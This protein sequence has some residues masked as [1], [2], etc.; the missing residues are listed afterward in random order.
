ML[1]E[2]GNA[3]TILADE[4]GQRTTSAAAAA[5][6]LPYD[7]GAGDKVMEWS[8]ATYKRLRKLAA[9]PQTGVS[10]L[11][12][13][14][15]SRRHPLAVPPWATAL[16]A[17]SLPNEARRGSGPLLFADGY[18]L[19]VPLMDT[20]RYLSYLADRLA[21]LGGT[22][23]KGVHLESFQDVS[24]GSGLDLI[25]NCA[26]IGARELAPD[27]EL[28][29]HRG[30]VAIVP[31]LDLPFAVACDDPPLM[32]AIPRERDCVFGGT[33]C[34]SGN[35]RPSAGETEAIVN[36][37]SRMLNIPPPCVLDSRVGLRPYRRPGVRLESGKL[38]D[39]TNIIHNYGHG[40]SGFTLSWGCAEEVVRLAQSLTSTQAAGPK[41]KQS[42]ERN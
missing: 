40:G 34:V 27:S 7:V 1:A 28:E 39:G 3:V 14:Q 10:M 13:R 29:P 33:N 9:N 18:S 19:F 36:E 2:A 8:L 21:A 16:G 30:Q 23:N 22:I 6:W 5:I 35:L 17:R 38:G 20:T 24:S 15:L 31:K 26:G 25:V 37:C 32:Y 11:E 42:P 12:L 41:S 4:S